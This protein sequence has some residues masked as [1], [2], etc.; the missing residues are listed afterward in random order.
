TA[1]PSRAVLDAVSTD[2]WPASHAARRAAGPEPSWTLPRPALRQAILAAWIG[3]AL[4]LLGWLVTGAITARRIVFAARPLADRRWQALLC[5][6]PDRLGL[7]ELP[8]LLKSDRVAMPFAS[9]LW[10]ST[11]VLPA[12][13]EGWSEERRRLVLFHELAHVKRRDLLGHTLGRI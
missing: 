9:G 10:R 3:I 13:A 7:A 8:P 1:A 2:R 12:D 11:I 4:A 6:A 5:E